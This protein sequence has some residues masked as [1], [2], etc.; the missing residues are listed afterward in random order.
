MWSMEADKAAELIA[1]RLQSYDFTGRVAD[2]PF[3]AISPGLREAAV[4]MPLVWHGDGATVLFTRRTDHLSSHPGQVSFPGGKL[5]SGDVS[6]QAAALREAREE[7][8]LPESSV[9]VLGSLPEYVTITG[10]VV[11]PVVGLLNPPLLLAPAADE[12]AEVFEVPLSLLLN[13]DAY[14][15]HDYVR[16]GVAG[17]YLSLQWGKHTIWGAT[18]AMM[19]MLADALGVVGV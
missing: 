5:E 3:R 18:A 11:T 1:G 14:S 13:R 2:M 10:F 15:R 16:E 7:T 6:A 9:R 17:Q 12:V 8:G 19:W 4:L